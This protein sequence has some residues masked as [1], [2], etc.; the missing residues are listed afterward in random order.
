MAIGCLS[1]SI[2]LA[3]EPTKSDAGKDASGA[4]GQRTAKD[5]PKPLPEIVEAVNKTA[6]EA[7]KELSKAG[8]VVKD[9]ANKA[10]KNIKSGTP[11]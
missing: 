10:Y 1:I 2:V 11:K 4:H 9:A 3:G 8:Q 5:L 6:V 7:G